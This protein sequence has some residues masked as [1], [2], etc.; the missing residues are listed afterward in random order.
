MKLDHESQKKQRERYYVTQFLKALNYDFKSLDSKSPPEPDF[1]LSIDDKIIGIEET[2]IL[3]VD[4]K[5]FSRAQYISTCESITARAEKIFE[6][7]KTQ[8]DIDVCISFTDHSGTTSYKAEN[9]VKDK[10]EQERLAIEI[11]SLVVNNMPWKDGH[12]AI[13][14]YYDPQFFDILSP[15][16][17][18]IHIYSTTGKRPSFWTSSY[19]GTCP[20]LNSELVAET[21]E[22]KNPK[23]L[24]YKVQYNEIWLL[25]T[26]HKFRYDAN[27]VTDDISE[28][29][30]T[31]FTTPFNRIFIFDVGD[32]KIIELN[33]E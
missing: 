21:I 31:N 17:G 2:Q 33:T 32:D 29:I 25:I 15:K 22:K 5:G 20:K 8:Q 12:Q 13:I 19:A 14:D 28:V 23:P 6:N 24:K 27:F 1:T 9:L 26:I 3:Y 16:I 4:N 11:A 30:E 18:F 10:K 7:Y